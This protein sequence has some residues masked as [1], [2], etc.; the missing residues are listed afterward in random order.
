MKQQ[1]C[2]KTAYVGSLHLCHHPHLPLHLDHDDSHGV[3]QQAAVLA[4]QLAL[5]RLR[6]HL[7]R[8]RCAPQVGTSIV[9]IIM[10]SMMIIII[11]NHHH[12]DPQQHHQD[13]CTLERMQHA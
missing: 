13:D 10:V 6:R 8:S 11:N 3:D 1:Y 12:R 9:I 5:L 4:A 2:D 7:P